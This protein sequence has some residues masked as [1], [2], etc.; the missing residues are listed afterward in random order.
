[1]IVALIT[2]EVLYLAL[3]HSTSLSLWK[4]IDTA[5]GSVTRAR[6]LGLRTQLQELCQ[7]GTTTTEYLGRAKVLVEEL[8]MMRQLVTLDTQNLYISRQVAIS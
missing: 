1:M 5:F 2:E 3:G 6:S 8:A 7:G 4:E